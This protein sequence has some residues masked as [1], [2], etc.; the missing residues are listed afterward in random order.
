MCSA[1]ELYS[2]LSLELPPSALGRAESELIAIQLEFHLRQR[3]DV[4]ELLWYIQFWSRCGDRE[5]ANI[6]K[7]Y[8]K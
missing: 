6:I 8:S 7:R 3:F 5:A 1:S 4:D 2:L